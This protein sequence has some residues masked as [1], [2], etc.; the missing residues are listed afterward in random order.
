ME[1]HLLQFNFTTFLLFT[2]FIFLLVKGW[3]KSKSVKENKKYPPSPGWKLPL[4]GHLHL[5]MGALPHRSLSKLSKQYGPIIHLKLGEVSSIVISSREI[6]KKVLTVNDLAV[7]DRPESIGMKTLWYD[8]KDLAFSPYNEHWRQMRKICIMELL[9]NKNVRSFSHIRLDETSNLIKSVRSHGGEPFNM[10]DKIFAFTSIATS[11]AAFGEILKE[12]DT[13]I[14]FMKKGVTL[15]GGFELADLY[16]SL[17][18][19]QIF[20]WNKHQLLKMRHKLDSILDVMLNEHK[21]KLAR[22]KRDNGEL[23]SENIVDVLLRKQQSDDLDVPITDD[24][25]KAIIF[26]M[27]TAGT[28]T[29]STTFDWVMTELMRNPRVMAKAQAEIREA[30]KGK[31]TIEESDIQSLKYLKLIIKENFRVHPAVTLLPRACRE[32]CEVDGYTI[33][34]KAKVAVNIWALGRDPEYWEEPEIFK[35]E[36]FENSSVDFLGNNFEFIPFGSGRRF[37]PGMNFGIANIDVPLAQLLYHFDWKLPHGMNHSDLDMS[38][39]PGVSV[40]RKNN[41]YLIAT[42]YNPPIEG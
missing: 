24:N 26:D 18:F 21:H 34:Y 17:K 8:Y 29:S 22:G 15:A 31:K 33:P 10:T 4:I 12:Q 40:Q 35:P 30:F 5:M 20:S 28:E 19:L 13:L 6:A 11:R 7:A 9:S 32:E 42:P 38:E 3:K 14:K 41:L 1:I 23:G 36:R 2:S 39:I 37:C 16:P 27:F 25:I